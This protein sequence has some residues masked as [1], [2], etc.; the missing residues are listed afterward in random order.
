[1]AI[2]GSGWS[3]T[4]AIHGSGWS[5]TMAIHGSGWSIT[6][7][8]I[9]QQ[10]TIGLAH[11]ER[12][13]PTMKVWVHIVHVNFNFPFKLWAKVC[14]RIIPKCISYSKFYGN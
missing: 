14:L 13:D 7:A 1:M 2:H 8:M 12:S 3:I 4:M 6:M 9:S 11:A 10:P 5:I